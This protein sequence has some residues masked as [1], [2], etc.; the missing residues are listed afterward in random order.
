[1][2]TKHKDQAWKLINKSLNK[3]YNDL[4]IFFNDFD[5]NERNDNCNLLKMIVYVFC[6]LS[7]LFEEQDI[8]QATNVDFTADTGPKKT[9]KKSKRTEESYDWQ[10]NKDKGMSVLLRLLS[11]PLHRLFS[12]PVIEDEFIK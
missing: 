1:M 9:S 5:A 2:E 6:S 7:E 12:P 4:E 3:L 8:K 10:Q 11:L